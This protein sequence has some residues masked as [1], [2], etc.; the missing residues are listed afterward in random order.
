MLA[1]AQILNVFEPLLHATII[2]FLF[3]CYQNKLTP[4]LDKA[5]L[6]TWFKHISYF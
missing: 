4:I 3:E 1:S 6:D 2:V 5:K